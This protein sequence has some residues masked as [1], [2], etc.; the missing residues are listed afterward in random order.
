MKNKK[1]IMAAVLLASLMPQMPVA[2]ELSSHTSQYCEKHCRTSELRKEVTA[3]EQAIE[4]A[5]A[6]G[7]VVGSGKMVE[8]QNRAKATREHLAKHEKELADA[9]AELDKAETELKQM[10]NK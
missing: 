10:E 2:A 5:K 3:L 7:N 1:I 9:Q 8:I 6:E 4:K